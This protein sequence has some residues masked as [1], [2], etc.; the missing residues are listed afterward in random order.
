M[1]GWAV[2][3]DAS[4]RCPLGHRIAR[5]QAP[6]VPPAPPTAESP[7]A[8]PD[9]LPGAERADALLDE[10]LGWDASGPQGPTGPTG[11]NAPTPT[12]GGL[13]L[14][15]ALLSALDEL[16]ARVGALSSAGT[17]PAGPQPPGNQ[18]P[19]TGKRPPSPTDG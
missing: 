1:C 19:A 14:D 10:L 3:I 13:G 4:G 8:P 2:T 12:T 9:D 16:E 6:P 5:P 17:S 11:A 15:A 18:P 7:D